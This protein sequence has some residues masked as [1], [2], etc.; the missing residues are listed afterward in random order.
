[1]EQVSKSRF[2]RRANNKCPR[3][4][5]VQPLCCEQA[6]TRSLRCVL[7]AIAFALCCSIV[8]AQ[9]PKASEYQVKAAY[10]LNFGKFVKWPSTSASEKSESFAA[11][12]LGADPF[13]ATLDATLAGETLDNKPVVIRRLSKPQDAAGCR[14]LFISSAEEKRLKE[15]LTA[16][17]QASVL[18]VSDMPG[19]SKRGGMIEFVLEGSRVRFEINLASAENAK[20]SLSSELLKVAASVRRSTGSGD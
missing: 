1:V 20:L 12:V 11:C 17:D 9:Q 16:I 7:G 18:T 3:S 14:I 8:L 5:R 4:D 6:M 19:F 13:G 10:L 15:I 2:M